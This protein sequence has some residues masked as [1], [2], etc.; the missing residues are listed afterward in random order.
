M[1]PGWDAGTGA[2]EMVQGG[3]EKWVREFELDWIGWRLV[4]RF[5]IGGFWMWML[6]AAMSRW[7]GTGRRLIGK[8]VGSG[9]AVNFTWT[10]LNDDRMMID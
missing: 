1:G 4:A 5:G 6:D 8:G 7:T 2:G 9:R 10:G 3:V